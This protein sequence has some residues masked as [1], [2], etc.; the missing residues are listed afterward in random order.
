[1]RPLAQLWRSCE[2]RGDGGAGGGSAAARR[3]PC[4]LQLA[5]LEPMRA[6]LAPGAIDA[7]LAAYD[8]EERLADRWRPRPHPALCALARLAVRAAGAYHGVTFEGVERLPQGP[9]LLVGNHGLMGYESPFFFEGILART[10]RLPLGLADRWFFRLPLV[11]DL[12]VRLGGAYGNAVTA[13]RLLGAGEL[14]VCYPGGARECFKHRASDRY[15]LLWERSRGFA[16]VALECGVPVV[17][18]AAAGVDDTFEVRGRRGGFGRWWMG[19]DKYDPPHLRGRAGLPLPRAVPFL[20]RIGEPIH[21]A[22][23]P[24]TEPAAIDVHHAHAA[25]WGAAQSLLD[26]TVSDWR[27]RHGGAS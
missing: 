23:R 3:G 16:R 27:A 6:S 4:G 5:L 9:A 25:V 14:V 20:F 1:M 21:L 17:P 13:R 22:D 12:L 18:F 10:R 2:A 7:R 19:H 15:R 26:D 11:R 8:D 24:V